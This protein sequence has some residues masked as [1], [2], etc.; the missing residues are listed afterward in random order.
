VT[1]TIKKKKTPIKSAITNV[2][3]YSFMILRALRF[4]FYVSNEPCIVNFQITGFYNKNKRNIEI[5]ETK[6][7]TFKLKA[8]SITYF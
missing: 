6:K 4:D 5:K 1:Y 2:K 7:V 3:I 8:T